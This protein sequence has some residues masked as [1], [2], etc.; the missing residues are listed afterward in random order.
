MVDGQDPEAFDAIPEEQEDGEEYVDPDDL[1]D[2]KEKLDVAAPCGEY[3]P[4][5]VKEGHHCSVFLSHCVD[6]SQFWCQVECDDLQVL[7]DRMQGLSSCVP[8]S[9]S[10][11]LT[12]Y[13][14]GSNDCVCRHECRA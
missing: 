14:V 9:V 11:V 2:A 12:C 3:K 13:L 5:T 8:H 7:M 4:R 1:L 10:I 6:P